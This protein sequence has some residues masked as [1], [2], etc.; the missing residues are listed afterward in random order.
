MASSIFLAE[1]LVPY[2]LSPPLHVGLAVFH[3]VEIG[4]VARPIH[5]GEF[6]FVLLKEVFITALAL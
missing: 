3:R 1:V 6:I 5:N 4:T 2:S